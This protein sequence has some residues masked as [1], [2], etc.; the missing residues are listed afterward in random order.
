MH[1]LPITAGFRSFSQ[2]SLSLFNSI[3]LAASS[4]LPSDQPA[5][6]MIRVGDDLATACY[7]L[8]HQEL[9]RP[10][11]HPLIELIHVVLT[12]MG[13]SYQLCPPDDGFVFLFLRCM[14]L[15]PSVG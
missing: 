5:N 6:G 10:A 7:N 3:E 15:L 4:P 14:P 11:V 1:R 8:T 9:S 12:S 2:L 13:L